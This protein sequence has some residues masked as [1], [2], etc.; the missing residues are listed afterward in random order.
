MT[1][2]DTDFTE[3]QPASTAVDHYVAFW[4]ASTVDEQRRLAGMTFVDGITCHAPVG[5]LHGAGALIGF[6]NQFAENFPDY[7]FRPRSRP[8]SHHGRTRLSWELI[9][10]GASFAT[11][12]DVL[13]HDDDGRITA[14]ITF[15]DRA[16][17]GFAQAHH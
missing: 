1:D 10:A 5:V 4:N 8:E 17:E 15:L 3:A 11:G 12:T 9:V 14:I 6:R 13:Q 2:T 16:P 7:V